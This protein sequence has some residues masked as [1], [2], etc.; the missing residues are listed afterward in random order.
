MMPKTA[1]LA[2]DIPDDFGPFECHGVV[3]AKKNG[4]LVSPEIRVANRG[5]TELEMLG[6]FCRL[7]QHGRIEIQGADAAGNPVWAEIRQMPLRLKPQAP[8]E[9]PRIVGVALSPDKAV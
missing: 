7:M 2:V 1:I 5:L 6:L 8:A 3:L 4:S 9:K